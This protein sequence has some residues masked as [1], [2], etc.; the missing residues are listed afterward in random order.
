MHRRMLRLLF[1]ATLCAALSI[2]LFSSVFFH[3]QVASAETETLEVDQSQIQTLIEGL[4]AA[5]YAERKQA[6]AAL[7]KIGL[8]AFDDLLEA[9]NH[10]EIEIA[11]RAR[12]LVRRLQVRWYRDDDLPSVKEIL[13]NYEDQPPQER[14][15][16]MER[17][18]R[19]PKHHG[20]EALCRLVR[21][22]TSEILSK[23]AALLVMEY[24]PKE[25]AVRDVF[26]RLVESYIGKSRRQAAAWLRVYMSTLQD[27]ESM[28]AEWE[29]LSFEEYDSFGQAPDVETSRTIAR[30][31][32]RWYA[33]LLR[34][35]NRHEEATEA[36]RLTIDLIESTRTQ[37][38][39]EV[40]WLIERK[41]YVLVDEVAERYAA[42]FNKDPRLIYRLAEAQQRRG[43]HAV[44][45]ETARRALAFEPDQ[46]L[47][48]IEVASEL[49]TRGFLN[50]AENEYR[51]VLTSTETRNVA[52]M[53]AR[54]SL[55]E[56]LHDLGR[57][58]DAGEVSR[59]LVE[60]MDQEPAVE[61]EVNKQFRSL[62]A[63]AIRSRSLYLFSR[64]HAE[65]GEHAKE[66]ELLREAIK[67]YPADVDVL[68]A[69]YRVNQEDEE[70]KKDVR[71]RI[72]SNV[73]NYEKKIVEQQQ[74]II[75]EQR[76]GNSGRIE[77]S[78]RLL[79]TNK[80][81]LA[82]LISNTEG[83]F[84][85]AIQMS[86]DSLVIRPNAPGY[87]DTLGRCYY[88]AGDL[89]NAIKYQSMAVAL[90]PHSGLIRRQLEFFHS[91]TK[92]LDEEVKGEDPEAKK[93]T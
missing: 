31:I 74:E 82:W 7:E 5:K 1:P 37:L 53:F 23:R 35:L 9:Q 79:A 14:R 89:K 34:R 33:N 3:Q 42:E 36:I 78:R 24:D 77:L 13:K 71:Q 85:R 30:D 32:L 91:E 81:Q 87:L 70:W 76:R 47:A 59:V 40:D 20:V 15:S 2:D 22:E 6:Q 46:P 73:A 29:R 83:D 51:Q 67:I 68:I 18:S 86:H 54:Y 45:A 28:L 66:I 58:L 12:Y 17:L 60:L 16:R 75:K 19:L 50:W 38:L 64:H 80:N 61:Q 88:A 43:D 49:Q 55:W 92:K 8:A 93:A 44:A 48:H 65:L 21:F 41:A 57:E 10:D 25:E 72:A 11:L 84:H 39:G 63:E 56:M 90:E 4:G 27:A 62:T 26:T 69:M 52:N